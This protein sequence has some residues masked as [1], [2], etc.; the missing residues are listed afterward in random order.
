FVNELETRDVVARAIAKEIF[1]GREAF[2][3]LRHLGKEV[4]EKKLPSLY[5]SAYLQAGID[6]CNE[7]LPI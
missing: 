4:I 6:V 7:L 3:D 1:M 5:K 2:I